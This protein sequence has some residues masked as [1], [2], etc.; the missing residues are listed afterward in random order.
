MVTILYT[1]DTE[2]HSLTP[3]EWL[4]VFYFLKAGAMNEYT[5]AEVIRHKT[6]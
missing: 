4:F 1:S 6:I 5:D 2:S 3:G